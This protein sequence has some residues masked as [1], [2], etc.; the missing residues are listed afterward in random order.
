MY[1]YDRCIRISWSLELR[2]LQVELKD[3][4]P[5]LDFMV[6]S[7]GSNFSVG[8]RWVT[9]IVCNFHWDPKYICTFEIWF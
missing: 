8:Q 1:K 2:W 6:S 7:G 5:G 4:V 3:A 9:Q